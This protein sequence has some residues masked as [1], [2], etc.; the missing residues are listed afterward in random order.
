MLHTGDTPNVLPEISVERWL[1]CVLESC[2]V[3]VYLF[4]IMHTQ[5][6]LLFACNRQAI[7]PSYSPKWASK[8]IILA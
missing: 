3:K 5:Q 7:F 1:Y 4:W 2:D 8:E 6:S